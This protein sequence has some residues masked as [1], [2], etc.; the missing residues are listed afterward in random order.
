MENSAE[1]CLLLWK[2]VIVEWLS[3]TRVNPLSGNGPGASKYYDNHEPTV[4]FFL[5]FLSLFPQFSLSF[6]SQLWLSLPFLTSDPYFLFCLFSIYFS[7]FF[8][9]TFPRNLPNILLG[10]AALLFFVVNITFATL[11]MKSQREEN[12]VVL[13]YLYI[14]VIINDGLFLAVATSLIIVIV[15]LMKVPI[16]KR[17]LE[18]KVCMAC[19]P[20]TCEK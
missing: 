16:T 1:W 19:P 3:C 6:S 7:S 17:S 11:S 13:S 9:P 12:E 4:K 10:I 8:F 14:R 5:T 2:M 18:A 15:K 20:F